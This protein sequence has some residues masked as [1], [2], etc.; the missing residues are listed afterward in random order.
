[1][2]EKVL[3]GIRCLYNNEHRIAGKIDELSLTATASNY[4]SVKYL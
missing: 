1:M 2:E 3:G 4:D